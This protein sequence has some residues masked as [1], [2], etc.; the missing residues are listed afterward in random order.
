VIQLK[1]RGGPDKAGTVAGVKGSTSYFGGVESGGVGPGRVDAVH[2][3]QG[4][5]INAIAIVPG[6]WRGTTYALVG[7]VAETCQTTGVALGRNPSHQQ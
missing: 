6:E 2:L 1:P 5:R 4:C 7:S 3:H